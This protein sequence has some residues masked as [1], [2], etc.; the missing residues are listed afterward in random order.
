MLLA[1]L[2]RPLKLALP[3]AAEDAAKLRPTATEAERLDEA[4]LLQ[5]AA[6]VPQACWRG[7]VLVASQL[8]ASRLGTRGFGPAPLCA[9]RSSD[10]AAQALSGSTWRRC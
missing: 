6:D 10:A 4:K 9:L 1:P 2:L 5:L 8:A 7:A 3:T